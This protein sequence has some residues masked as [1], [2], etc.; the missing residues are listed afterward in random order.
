MK[1]GIISDTHG[2]LRPEVLA[3]LAGVDHILHA[4]DVGDWKILEALRQVA[5]TTAIRGNVD[6]SGPCAAL[7]ETEAV[8]LAGRLFYL[9]HSIH[10]LD[11]HPAAAG[12][13]TIISGH[14]HQPAAETLDGILFLNPGS[15]GPRRFNLPTTIAL[16]EVTEA[17]R[18]YRFIDLAPVSTRP[19]QSTGR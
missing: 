8:E 3:A 6:T 15:A 9:V 19:T 13:D 17:V 5:P 14:S 16:L 11:I 2:L 1:I 18:V 4:G 10:N 12:L 7:P